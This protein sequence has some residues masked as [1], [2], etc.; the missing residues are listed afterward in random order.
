LDNDAVLLQIQNGQWGAV[1]TDQ[2]PVA[3]DECQKAPGLFDRIKL[4]VDQFNRP[5]QY[6]LTGSV[7][8]LSKKQIRESLTGRTTIL[9]LLPLTLS[10]QHGL[11]ASDVVTRL[12]KTGGNSTALEKLSAQIRARFNQDDLD[13]YLDT[14][15][16]P[17]ICFRRD[18]KIRNDQWNAHLDTLFGR[19]IHLLYA[20]EISIAKLKSL[21][22]ILSRTQGEPL[23]LSHIARQVAVSSLTL[24]RLLSAMESL[25]L[26]RRIGKRYF[27]EDQGLA[28][29]AMGKFDEIPLHRI[30]RLV[31][32]ELF[33]QLQYGFRNEFELSNYQT[34]VGSE[35]PF[36]GTAGG[37]MFALNVD[38]EKVPSDRTLKAM[39]WFKKKHSKAMTV[40]LYGGDKS[41]MTK[42]GTLCL[43]VRCIF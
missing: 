35:I 18:K 15:G 2:Y 30:R 5:G 16:L 22:Q 40:I 26:L 34:R 38:P 28:T 42:T 27:C 19:D 37:I 8:F 36:I 32:Q 6:L 14:G 24:K 17:G 10:E 41:F 31:F 39:T 13:T 12:I 43:P 3:I 11:P 25:F 7:R 21:Y 4:R 23:N 29:F 20:T 33:S 9:E 1:E